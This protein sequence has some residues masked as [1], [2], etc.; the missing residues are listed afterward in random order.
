MASFLTNPIDGAETALAAD[1]DFLTWTGASDA[2]DA[3]ANYIFGFD[4]I[5]GA[6]A[7]QKYAALSALVGWTF[8][9]DAENAGQAAFQFSD[10]E[11]NLVFVETFATTAVNWAAA[12]RRTFEDTVAGFI[13]AFLGNMETNGY[14]ISRIM[15]IDFGENFSVRYKD[16][17]TGKKG[18]QYGVTVTLG[19]IG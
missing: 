18:Y 4:S 14:R 13:T 12:T 19:A 2:T 15:Q 16:N 5:D 6:N 3:K 7:P 8:E 1:A 11:F 10:A 17:E 9:R